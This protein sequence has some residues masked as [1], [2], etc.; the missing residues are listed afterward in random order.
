MKPKASRL[1][2]ASQLVFCITA[3]PAM[4]VVYDWDNGGGTGAWDLN[5][6]WSPDGLPTTGDNVLVTVDGAVTKTI[7]LSATPTNSTILEVGLARTGN[8]TATVNHTGG[9]LTVTGWFN[10]GQGFAGTGD[11]NGTGIWNMSGNAVV[12][13]THASGGQTTI[14]AG[15]TPTGYNTGILNIAGNA[16]FNQSLA[17]LFIGGETGALRA[18]GTVNVSEN[19]RL[20]NTN[21]TLVGVAGNGSVGVLNLSG[22]SQLTSRHLYIGVAPDSYGAVNVAGGSLTL[23]GDMNI[24]SWG[25]GYQTNGGNGMMNISAGT[26]TVGGWLCMSRWGGSQSS[27]LNVSGT[28]S[29]TYAGGGLQ[30]N[31]NAD[32]SDTSVITVSGSGS[33]ATTNNS[34][35]NLSNNASAN[36]TGILNLNGGTVTPSAV[37]GG[38][39]FV[40]FNG[41]TLRANSDNTNFLAVN[42]AQVRAGGAIIDTNSRNITIGQALVAPT[43]SGVTTIAVTTGGSGY[44]SAPILS[45]SGGTGSGATAIANM[46]DDGTGNGTF[47]IGSVTVTGAGNYTVAPTTI[48]Q[49]GGGATTAA[50]FGAFTTAA[51]LS[52][53]LTKIGSGTLTLSGANTYTGLTTV[54]AGTLNLSSTG[55][56]VTGADLITSDT[57]GKAMLTTSGTISRNRLWFGSVNGAVGAGYQTAG[58]VATTVVAGGSV[59]LGVVQGG[60]G[61]YRISGGSLTTEEIAIGTWGTASVNN[62]GGSGMLE[63]TGG[64]VTNNGWMVMNRT[65]GITSVAQQSVLNV[66]AGSLTY[67]GG[68]LQANWGS[69]GNTQTTV[70]NVSGTG[71]IATTVAANQVINLS[72]SGNAATTGILNLN[73][74]TVTPSRVIGGRGF[75]NFNGGT[76]RANSD[77]TDFL[78][79]NTAHVRAGGAI[80]DSN[81]RNITINQALLAPA[82][83]G[84][85]TIAVTN[86]GSGYV[87]APILTLSGGTGSGATAIAD[88]VD[89]GTGNG[90]FRIGS[91]TV[92]GAGNYTVAPTTITQTGGGAATAATLGAITTAANVSGGLTKNGLG[93]LTLSGTNTYTGL[94]TV[95]SGALNVTSSGSLASGN[96][97]SVGASGTADF[98]NAGQTLGAV[99]NANAAT[100]AL[101]FSASTG[102]VT[103]ASLTGAGN[104]RFGSNGTVTGGISTGTVTSV[105]ALNANISGG[106]ITAGGLLTG[107]ISS[108]TVGAGSLS[109]SAVSGGAVT[110]TALST[111]GTL[112]GSGTLGSGSLTATSVTGGTNQIT[113]AAGITTLNGG[114]TTVGG[115]ATLGTMSS[116]TAT[117]NGATSSIS[118]LNGGT[119]NLGSSTVL[120]VNNG[121]TSGSI[122][123][124]GGSLTKSSTGT[125][126]LSADGTYSY[127]GATNINEGKLVVN[128]NISTSS[129]TVG[130]NGT[131]GGSGTV[132]PTTVNGIFAPGNSI[133][134]LT[135][136]GALGLNGTSNFEIDPTAGLGLNRS[137]DLANVTGAVSYGGILNVQYGGSSSDFTNGM[138]FNLFDATSF[139]D[140]FSTINLPTLTGGLSWENNLLSNGSLVVIPEPGTA[141]LGG[142]GML[143]LLRRRR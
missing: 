123:G 86:G 134:T 84:V 88:M 6:N 140:G 124:S 11:R 65:E 70:I 74:G 139:T 45:I 125:L 35:I 41:G 55:S 52:G 32:G 29:L 57:A 128:G 71:S 91:I 82:N 132:G 31:W 135:I 99:S 112:S 49:T 75:V 28:G 24:G 20:L 126:T 97:L 109:S 3:L 59:S 90:T 118:T 22:T 106:T 138:V 95:T 133:G 53:G 142:L 21:D 116:G 1:L 117:L 87:S 64:T 111:I 27:V 63:I 100:N 68:G 80:I 67:A 114:N 107:T 16:T 40:N 89:D 58:T 102:T 5:T 94:T 23:S 33:L 60:Y 14:G 78:A 81:G 141:L 7:T 30:A 101:N 25:T 103:L 36:N 56:L 2:A 119:V 39:G 83:N 8:G 121:T 62:N 122:T 42:T 137:S 47:R 61:Y 79:V 13:A 113:G 15:W 26:V 77:Q 17:G 127:S 48:A 129:L 115:V 43:G 96:A 66:S 9:T 108:G 38:R 110:V 104:T 85:T 46:V 93:T 19:G 76:L 92:T 12:N 37:T 98:A 120:T 130:S 10:L 51:N 50:T 73:G 34:V 72:R 44:V 131:L 136:G 69:S 4:A 143:A 105:G 54:R 18:K